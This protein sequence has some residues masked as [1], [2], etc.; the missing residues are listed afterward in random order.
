[1]VGLDG[2]HAAGV[3]DSGVWVANP[4]E[5]KPQDFGVQPAV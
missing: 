2:V 5:I 1:M 3:A 4:F